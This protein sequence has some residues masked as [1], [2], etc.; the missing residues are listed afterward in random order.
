MKE[1]KGNNSIFDIIDYSFKKLISPTVMLAAA[2]LLSK[3]NTAESTNQ[4][5]VM[6][7]ICCLIGWSLVYF[8]ATTCKVIEE[9]QSLGKNKVISVLLCT[10][11]IN[12]YLVVFIVA[13]RSGID[14]VIV[15]Q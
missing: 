15:L 2:A 5:I 9:F 14:K 1:E 11:F 10:S 3:N 6:F 8:V 13:I 12:V 4:I 7:L